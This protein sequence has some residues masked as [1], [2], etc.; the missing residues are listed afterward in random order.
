MIDRH[1]K[2]GFLFPP[3]VSRQVIDDEMLSPYMKELV[4]KQGK[5]SGPTPIQTYHGKHLFLMTP[6]VRLYLDLGLKV[7]N[8]TKFIQY[9][10]GKCL[11]PFA[12]KVVQLRSEATDD[13]DDAKQLTAKLF[14]NAGIYP[15]CKI[16]PCVTHS[17]KFIPCVKF[18]QYVK[19]CVNF[20]L[21]QTSRKGDQSHRHQSLCRLEQAN[22]WWK[23]SL[24]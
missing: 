8:I 22:P 21:W 3:I 24:L 18:T 20:R 12:N 13:K 15:I 6:L 2:N 23:E 14:G 7:T 19:F 4:D 1:L 9:V 17:I 5:K 11:L 10:P 16:N